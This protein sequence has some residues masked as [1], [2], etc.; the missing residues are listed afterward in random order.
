M[1]RCLHRVSCGRFMGDDPENP[2]SLNDA[3]IEEL[4]LKV[5]SYKQRAD[6]KEIELA[7]LLTVNEEIEKQLEELRKNHQKELT[8]V[9]EEFTATKTKMLENHRTILTDTEK[10]IAK[11]DVQIRELIKDATQGKEKIDMAEKN[12][13][14]EKKRADALSGSVKIL[15][16]QV[17]EFKG[18]EKVVAQLEKEKRKTVVV[19]EGFEK[20]AQ[21]VRAQ[22]NIIKQEKEE[23]LEK[24][25]ELMKTKTQLGDENE[26]LDQQKK[27]FGHKTPYSHRHQCRS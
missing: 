27:R 17:Q 26:N 11:M 20:E 22:L 18:L 10:T 21:A 2:S 12:A 4:Q 8:V 3:S 13:D 23:L 25:G 19:K 14:V 6:V 7:S 16:E 1:Y 9:R 15:Q 24:Q 5:L